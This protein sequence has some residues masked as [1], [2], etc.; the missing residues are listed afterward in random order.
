M[1]MSRI[2]PF[3]PS[4]RNVED[5]LSMI[6]TE[7]DHQARAFSW[8]KDH[9]D[10]FPELD[11]L[12][13]LP[14]GGWRPKSTCQR[15]KEEGVKAGLP[16]VCLPI[17]LNGCGALYLELKR[18]DGKRPTRVQEDWHRRLR[19]RGNRVE[20]VWSWADL[21]MTVLDYLGYAIPKEIVNAAFFYRSR[22]RNYGK[23]A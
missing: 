17:P 21:I 5:D 23:A 19:L 14:L 10:D 22:R 6:V 7:H 11:D 12:F 4:N 3:L 1:T 8:A 2:I 13:A 20:V 15:L 9:I 18:P 16:D